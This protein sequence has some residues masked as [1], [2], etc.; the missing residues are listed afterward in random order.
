MDLD[1]PLLEFPG[2]GP[3]RA[4][5]LGRL[6]LHTAE[7]L[8]G[9]FP[10]G[11]EDRTR[12]YAIADAPPDAP[13]CVPALVASAPQFSRI[14]KG[15]EVTKV[16]VVDAAAA[17]SVTFF[18]QAYVRTA[19]VPGQEYVFYGKVERVGQYF[20]MT[21]PVFERAEQA[22]FTGRIMPIYPLTAGVSNNLLAGLTQRAVPDCAGRIPEAMPRDLLERHSLAQS[23]FS[24]KN[25]HFPESPEA[26]EL[27]RRRLI[28]EELFT[29]SA[30]LALLRERREQGEGPRFAPVD[31]QGFYGLLPFALTGAQ[32]RTIAECAADLTSGRPMNRLV[33]GDVGSGKTA[34]AAA[35]AWMA[36]ESG[37]QCAMM[38]PTEILAEQHYRSLTA[39]LEPAHMVVGLL[40]G[41]MR[42]A[43][44][45]KV[46]AALQSGDIHFVVGTHALLSEGVAFENLGL[47]VTDEQHRFGVEQRAALAAKANMPRDPPEAGRRFCGEGHG[48]PLPLAANE[49]LE[50]VPTAAFRRGEVEQ[51]AA[52]AAKGG[53][54]HPHVL[55]M[56]ATPI[57]RTLALIIYGDLDV[58]VI[59]ELPPGRMP[60]QTLL[61]GESKR[62]R[63]YGF[64]R[65]QV[66]AGRQVYI[67]CPAIEETEETDPG[68]ADLKRVVDYAAQLREQVFPDLRVGLVHGRMKA[69]DKEAAMAAFTAGETDILVSTTVI[70]VGVDVPNANLIIIENAD[71]YGLGQLHQLRG[72]VGRGR[73][74]SWCVLVSSNRSEETR[75]RLKV[76]V[77]TTDGFQIAEEDLKLRGPGDFFGARQ[78]GLPTLR[79]AD[80]NTDTRILKEAQ[81]AARGLLEAD[82]DLSQPLHRPLLDKVKRLFDQDPDMFN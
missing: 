78:H 82:P 70:E 42:A 17:M 49:I 26:L 64:V 71:R 66:K 18:N 69:R 33:Q 73:H 31:P 75:A 4:K 29:L 40:T 67:V 77:D 74:Q 20:R 9:Y 15:L 55:V 62:A 53:A 21:N 30:G 59:D 37:F 1:T 48:D 52:L 61:V 11:Y 6:G 57:P 50:G 16:K 23:E 51:R 65:E 39:L 27:A 12:Q 58:S 36:H 44:K 63:M 3:A 13:V 46:C 10:R 76:L 38:A 47:V 35:C 72:R 24:Y 60:I 22:R 19:L 56:S 7:D 41:S 28:F 14:R 80:L 34:V 32:K 81:D 43:E 2:V 5:A 79:V 8:M 25:I 68:F 54:S 45:R